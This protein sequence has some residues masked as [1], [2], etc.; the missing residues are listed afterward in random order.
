VTGAHK[1][2]FFITR[3]VR[4]ALGPDADPAARPPPCPSDL[5]NLASLVRLRDNLREDRHFSAALFSANTAA[6]EALR[7]AMAHKEAAAHAADAADAADGADGAA[8][9]AVRL[10]ADYTEARHIWLVD[11]GY[12]A[13][14]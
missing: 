2:R 14:L 6:A 5:A 8:E 3:C 9:R 12:A 13:S 4:W 7:S 10:F 11:N 1:Y